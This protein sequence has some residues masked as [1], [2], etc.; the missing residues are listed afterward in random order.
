MSRYYFCER[1]RW[2]ATFVFVAVIFAP[3]ALFFLV[4]LNE[5]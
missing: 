4:F 3:Y 2:L 1:D 5:Q